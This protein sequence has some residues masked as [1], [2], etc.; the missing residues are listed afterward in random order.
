MHAHAY[1]EDG[2]VHARRGLYAGFDWLQAHDA[3]NVHIHMHTHTHAHIHTYTTRTLCRR[4]LPR[5]AAM[6]R[7]WMVARR[8]RR[9]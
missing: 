2:H 9:I 7:G 3:E 6:Q 8:M 4:K 1:A 5:M